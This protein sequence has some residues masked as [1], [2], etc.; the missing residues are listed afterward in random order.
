MEGVG[1]ES[2]GGSRGWVGCSGGGDTRERKRA[3]GVVWS[4]VDGG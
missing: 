3:H 4:R 2:G 1:E